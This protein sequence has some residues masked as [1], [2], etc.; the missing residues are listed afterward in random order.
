MRQ[1]PVPVYW[2]R[3]QGTLS[4]VQ[5]PCPATTE[6]FV[7]ADTIA[8][9]S[10]TDTGDPLPLW[11]CVLWEDTAQSTTRLACSSYHSPRPWRM[12]L[13]S[14]GHMNQAPCFAEP[15]RSV[16]GTALCVPPERGV[17]ALLVVCQPRIRVTSDTCIAGRSDC[18][19]Y[20]HMLCVPVNPVP[21]TV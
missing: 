2:S 6:T 10:R 3:G 19:Q 13:S 17:V 16:G 9:H 11:C 12:L 14:C 20:M 7:S 1:L 8:A 4:I 18:R 5:P 21:L 15:A